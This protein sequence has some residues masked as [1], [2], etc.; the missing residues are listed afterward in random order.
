[1]VGRPQPRRGR[2]HRCE[3]FAW[4]KGL[5]CALVLAHVGA[6][7]RVCTAVQARATA[8]SAS[9]F[10]TAR[11]PWGDPVLRRRRF[12]QTLGLGLWDLDGYPSDGPLE[13]EFS[14]RLRLDADFGQASEE[15]DPQSSNYFVPGLEQAPLDVVHAYLDA[16]GL[17]DDTVGLRLGRQYLV[18][19]L[20]WWSFDGAL[21]RASLPIHLELEGYV[22]YEQRGGLPWMSTSRFERDGVYRGSRGRLEPEEWPSYLNESRPAPAWGTAV[23]LTGLRGVQA[24]LSYRRVTERDRIILGPFGGTGG[25]PRV[26][27]QDRVS[28]ER[29][30][31]SAGADE[32]GLGGVRA[33]AVYDA[34][35]RVLSEC[36]GSIEWVL[37]EALIF[38]LD[39]ASLRPTFDADSVFNFFAQ[40]PMQQAVLRADWRALRHVQISGTAGIR[41][42]GAD[43]EPGEPEGAATGE[44]DPGRGFDHIYSLTTRAESG[45][46]AAEIASVAEVGDSGDLIGSEI[47]TTRFFDD[48]FYDV[49]AIVSVYAWQ[50]SLRPERDS[51]SVTY[52]LG[53][54]ITPSSSTHAGLEWEHTVTHVWGHGFRLLAT[55]NLEIE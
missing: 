3:R 8:E 55:L 32:P 9:Q 26:Y 4:R 12:T 38:G 31:I 19:S 34:Y 33:Q 41:A 15:T 7:T 50:N 18:D 53:G 54:G 28:S 23:Q 14:A 36:Y 1:M 24:R 2:W 13:L 5:F 22:G 51:V 35:V 16:R 47:R 25:S 27:G 44:T 17:L 37:D 20:G 39:G 49:L 30:G 52:V 11:S 40:H 43:G 48:G 21:L 45:P 10:Y 46:G 29:L 42:F 6:E